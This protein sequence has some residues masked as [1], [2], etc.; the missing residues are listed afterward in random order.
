[1]GQRL[2]QFSEGTILDLME[3]T[4]KQPLGNGGVSNCSIQID[5]GG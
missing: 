1:M 5:F 3:E 2:G 4:D